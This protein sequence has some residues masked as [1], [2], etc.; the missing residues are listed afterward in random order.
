MVR[1]MEI[2]SL[3]THA[4]TNIKEHARGAE[5]IFFFSLSLELYDFLNKNFNCFTSYPSNT[6]RFKPENNDWR[7]LYNILDWTNRF[8]DSKNWLQPY[9]IQYLRRGFDG[10]YKRQNN[11]RQVLRTKLRSRAKKN[12]SLTRCSPSLSSLSHAFSVS[13]RPPSICSDLGHEAVHFQAA[14]P[15]HGIRSP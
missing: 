3:Q 4:H 5:L 10:K 12:N 6:A 9:H 15:P 7:T 13:F 14:E 2:Y 8:S 11:I 1:M